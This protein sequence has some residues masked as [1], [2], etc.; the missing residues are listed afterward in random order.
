MQRQDVLLG[1]AKQPPFRWGTRNSEAADP[2]TRSA[3]NRRTKRVLRTAS[4]GTA[5]QRRLGSADCPRR[6][7][8]D[9][10][11]QSSRTRRNGHVVTDTHTGT[12]R[13]ATHHQSQSRRQHGLVL[14]SSILFLI[15][16]PR[17][18]SKTRKSWTAIKSP[19]Y[20]VVPGADRNSAHGFRRLLCNMSFQN[21]L[22]ICQ[23]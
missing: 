7:A 21:I 19:S 23:Q 17:Y 2:S 5:T 20:L 6:R 3:G 9:S 18:H 13:Q 4:L 16:P 11:L 8:P 15:I 1:N 12:Q 10:F 22:G 14:L